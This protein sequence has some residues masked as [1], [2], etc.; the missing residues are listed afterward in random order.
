MNTTTDGAAV[1]ATKKGLDAT[2][3]T[4]EDMCSNG[5]NNNRGSGT[6]G[7]EAKQAGM[8]TNVTQYRARQ[9]EIVWG[10]D[11]DFNYEP[12]YLCK[13]MHGPAACA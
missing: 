9:S 1:Q 4:V 3:D 13:T 5:P 2:D 12:K 11:S 8:T 7:I 10:R 6:G